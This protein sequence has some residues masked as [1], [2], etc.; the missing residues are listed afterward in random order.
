MASRA[1]QLR[2]TL[3]DIKP[4]IWRRLAVPE[5]CGGPPGYAELVTA[6]A[7]PQHEQHEERVEWMD[8]E[9]DPDAFD[10][11]DVNAALE[12]WRAERMTT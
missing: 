1:Y 7:D 11:E 2:I 9:F 6:I 4:P 10:I 3:K 8:G 12:Q 5:D